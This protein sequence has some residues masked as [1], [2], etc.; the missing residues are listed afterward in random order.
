MSVITKIDSGAIS[1]KNLK[2]IGQT[3]K[4]AKLTPLKNKIIIESNKEEL[5]EIHNLQG[6]LIYKDK[7][8]VPKTKVN[9]A[10]IP[11]GIY[12]IKVGKLSRKWVKND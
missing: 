4:N 2:I 5:Y 7:I 12:I 3:T 8:T 9:I 11:K 10:A 1:I 6:K